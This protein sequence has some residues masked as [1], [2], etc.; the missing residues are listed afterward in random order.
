MTHLITTPVKGDLC[1]RCRTVTLTGTAEGLHARVDPIAL[2]GAGEIAALLAGQTT[3]TLTRTEL[4]HRD[5]G[6]IAGTALKGPV[7]AEHRCHRTVPA[8]HRAP[9]GPAT[10]QPTTDH[11]QPPY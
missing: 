3:Y 11:D 5:P 6:R 10:T 9:P 1:P 4:V 8:D 2:N 7:V